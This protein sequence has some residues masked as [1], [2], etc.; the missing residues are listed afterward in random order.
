LTIGTE[1]S[2]AFVNIFTESERIARKPRR[3][4]TM[5]RSRD[6]GT[7]RSL[8]TESRRTMRSVTLVDVKAPCSDIVGVK[9]ISRVTHA[10]SVV[11]LV[12]LAVRVRT[13]LYSLTGRFTRSSLRIMDESFV[14]DA[15]IS[16]FLM[17]IFSEAVSTRARVTARSVDTH[18]I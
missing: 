15:R 1:F 2:A 9:G 6:V 16:T 17:R 18:S 14:A 3:A 13:T 10:S 12:D 8:S 5:M 7:E 11:S 4:V